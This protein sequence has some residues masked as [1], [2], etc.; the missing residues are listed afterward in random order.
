MLTISAYK[1]RKTAVKE[2]RNVRVWDEIECLEEEF[3]HGKTPFRCPEMVPAGVKDDDFCVPKDCPK[4][5]PQPKF[6]SPFSSF[7]QKELVEIER[8]IT[9]ANELLLALSAEDDDDEANARA[10]QVSLRSFRNQFVTVYYSCKEKKEEVCGYFL[11]AGNDFIIIENADTNNITILPTWRLLSIYNMD[12]SKKMD[13][14]D[15]Q[16]LLCI[17]PCLRRNLTFH[18]G[19]IVTRSPYLL[20]IFFGLKLSMLLESYV[21]YYA[22]IQTETDK[23]EQDGTLEKVEESDLLLKKYDEEQWIDFENICLIELEK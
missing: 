3:I 20:N 16:E 17:N 23:F 10:L 14:D 8:C 13:D 5:L 19:E 7:P 4:T 1:K 12:R 9:L 2:L 11:D 22:Y 18:F 15:E 21:G 6:T